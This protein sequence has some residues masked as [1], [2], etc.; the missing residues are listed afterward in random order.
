[1]GSSGPNGEEWYDA[2]VAGFRKNDQDPPQFW[3]MPITKE[4][5]EPLA[6]SLPVLS[7]VHQHLQ[8]WLA[9]TRWWRAHAE[10]HIQHG[11]IE[12]AQVVERL[13]WEAVTSP[14]ISGNVLPGPGSSVLGFNFNPMI[15]PFSSQGLGI[16]HFTLRSK[17]TGN[18]LQ[19]I[20]PFA[21]RLR[22]PFCKTFLLFAL[23]RAA[24]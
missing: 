11:V 19:V 7:F 13:K 8:S 20:P 24:G 5:N 18:L 17:L 23:G 16:R 10:E 4:P 12:H 22:A 15:L 6:T 21:S 14:V 1:M 3:P 9:L 2:A